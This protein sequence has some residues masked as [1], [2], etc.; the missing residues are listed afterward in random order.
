MKEWG[1]EIVFLHR[2][3]PGGTDDSYG[4]YVAK[5]AGIPKEVIKR[6][7]QILRKLELQND[8]EQKMRSRTATGTQLPLFLER[9]VPEDP[10]VEGIKALKEIEEE[11]ANLDLNSLT[12][13]TALNKIAEWKEKIKNGKGTSAAA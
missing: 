4:I 2:I 11:M 5:L 6:S 9:E 1:K 12:P 3:I 7:Q 10:V 8:L 13:L